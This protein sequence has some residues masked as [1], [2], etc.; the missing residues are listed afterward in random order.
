MAVFGAPLRERS[1]FKNHLILAQTRFWISSFVEKA[2]I[3]TPLKALIV[4]LI[5]AFVKN[6]SGGA[7]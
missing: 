7:G 3:S 2:Q 4:F 1:F 5:L 6:S